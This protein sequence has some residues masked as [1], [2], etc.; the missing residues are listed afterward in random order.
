MH[1]RKLGG[2]RRPSS[3]R[4]G[5]RKSRMVGTATQLRSNHVDDDDEII[6]GEPGSRMSAK[7]I[8]KQEVV[9]K[10]V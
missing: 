9:T 3:L 10:K 2:P 7:K 1:L 5:R 6:G 8:N 4:M